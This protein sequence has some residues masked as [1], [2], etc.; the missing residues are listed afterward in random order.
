MA[1]LA[2]VY[3]QAVGSPTEPRTEEIL[4]IAPP[5]RSLHGGYLVFHA[6]EN[7]VEID[8]HH[9]VPVIDRVVRGGLPSAADPGAVHGQV[10]PAARFDSV[11]DRPLD[12]V[13]IGHIDGE[14]PGL[15]AKR[16]DFA[17]NIVRCIGVHVSHDH[18]G[19]LGP[20]LP[21]SRGAYPG[22]RAKYQ[23]PPSL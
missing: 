1:C 15:A 17:G 22:A 7:A 19:A 16:R 6:M 23:S 18:L 3:A 14:V 9:F 2:A 10:Q 4:T 20:E 21:G 5:P 12:G 11:S 8:V 13:R